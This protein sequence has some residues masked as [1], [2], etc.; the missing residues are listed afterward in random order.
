MNTNIY[1]ITDSH[2]ES[3]NLSRLLSGI[4]SLEK[5]SKN[6]FLI[7]DAGDLFKGIYDKDL[8]VNAYLKIKEL[9]PQSQIFITIGNNDFG[10]KKADFEY[11]KSTIEK[12]AKAGI[13]VVCANI[14]DNSTQKSVDWVDRYKIITINNQRILITGF[15]LNNSCANKFKCTLVEI[16]QS[17]KELINKIKEPYDKLIILNHHWYSDSKNLYDYAKENNIKVCF[18]AGT[19]GIRQ[20][21][22]YLKHILGIADIVVMNKE[23]ASLSSGIKVRPD[24]KNIHYSEELIHPDVKEMLCKLKVNPHQVVII[25]DGGHG[26]YAYD[27]RDFYVCPVFDSPVVS[28]LGAGDAFASTFF[29]AMK[30][31]GCDIGKSLMYASVESS[32]VVSKFGATEGLIPFS[33]IKHLL[34][35]H[36][37]YS[38]IK[39]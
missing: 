15:C 25:T 29:A 12:F 33:E 39:L 5:S 35:K 10:F 28:T 19:T 14:I 23:E 27:G 34:E 26:A 21:F 6:P 16:K 13:N 32:S 22:E 2:Q 36:P 7:L 9:I 1:A 18:N 8:S 31:T 24:T 4:Y 38:Y 37:Q 20:G 11:L 3:R 17:L 30:E